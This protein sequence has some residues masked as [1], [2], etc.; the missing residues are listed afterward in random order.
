MGVRLCRPKEMVQMFATKA[1]FDEAAKGLVII[2]FTSTW[3]PPCKMI[4]PIFE[5]IAEENAAS[6]LQ[7]GKVD[8]DANAEASTAA[9]IS[10]MPTFQV[11]KGGEKIDE[12]VG[13]SEDGLRALVDK[14]K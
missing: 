8:V 1:E 13:A 10:A 6:A 9:G 2:D 4:G 12:L 3:C 5:K 7:F 14:Y 11:W